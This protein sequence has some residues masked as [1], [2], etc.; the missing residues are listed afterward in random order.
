[1]RTALALRLGRLAWALAACCALLLAGEVRVMAPQ[2]SESAYRRGALPAGPVPYRPYTLAPG[3]AGWLI[4]DTWPSLYFGRERAAEIRR[5]ASRLPWARRLVSLMR[6]EAELALAQPPQ[7]P[8]EPCGWRHDF[9]SRTSAAHLRYEPDRA[10]SFLDPTTGRREGDPAQRRAWALLTHE[11]TYRI[12]R[13]LGVLYQ[14]TGDERYARWVAQGLRLAAA[15]F[16]H[17]EFGPQDALYYSALYDAGV[18]LLVGNAYDLT[19]TSPAYTTA[20]HQRLRTEIFDSRL[21]SLLAY[22]DRAG[23]HNIACF[24]AAAVAVAGQVMERPDWLRRGLEAFHTQL[25]KGI[26]TAAEA[27][28]GFWGEGTTFYHFYALCPLVALYELERQV[29]GKVDPGLTR[30][31]QAAFAAPLALVDQQGRLP[32]LG[33]LGDPAQLHLAAYRHLYEYA[34]GRLDNARFGPVLAATYQLSGAPR[35][36]LAALAFGPDRL[37]P[38]GGLPT[39]HTALPV[40]GIGIFRSPGPPPCWLL[41]R[42]GPYHG[43]H[44]HP[45]RL[46]LFL[47]AGALVSPDLGEPGYSLRPRHGSFYGSTLAHNTLFADETDTRG[48]ATLAWRPQARPPQAQGCL[49]AEGARYQRTVFFDPPYLVIVDHC[50][51]DRERRFGCIYRA[52][53]ELAV[54]S[55]ALAAPVPALGLPP[56]PARGAWANLEARRS[57]VGEC[58]RATW[59]VAP[60]LVLHLL[61]RSDGPLEVTAGRLPGNPY[62]DR[63]GALLLRA[64]GRTRTFCTV[65]ELA[66]GPSTVTDLV[67][68]PAESVDL[69]LVDRAPRRYQW[70]E[71]PAT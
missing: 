70:S 63:Q 38:P 36:D 12:M 47:H 57:G 21:P 29:Q 22:L 14:V 48:D 28:D 43:G 69:R 20:D 40:A 44:D 35:T 27:L 60:G 5:K 37:P 30:R 42:A 23:A 4:E 3:D 52:R 62:A 1:M 46:S 31:L 2:E 41:F 61:T 65:L 56:L 50:Q 59:Q 51:A 66:A 16:G 9:F 33:D 54:A 58:V 45:D 18:L 19:R 53:G 68:G 67:P 55:P 8:Q 64:P 25:S 7:L 49:Q 10:D 71:Q 39:G 11:R 17:Q 15:Y 24:V 13:S 26:P 34:A 32:A 6:Q